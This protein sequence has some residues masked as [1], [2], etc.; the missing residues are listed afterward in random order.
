VQEPP[1]GQVFGSS[2]A[3]EASHSDERRPCSGIVVIKRS[4]SLLS[5]VPAVSMDPTPLLFLVGSCHLRYAHKV[6]LPGEDLQTSESPG[7]ILTSHPWQ[8]TI[9]ASHDHADANG[10]C[11]GSSPQHRRY[12]TYGPTGNFHVE[13]AAQNDMKVSPD[14]F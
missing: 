11:K 3:R 10:S 9:M 4:K 6:L 14:L 2:R 1:K 7:T 12:P 5:A 8:E 13:V